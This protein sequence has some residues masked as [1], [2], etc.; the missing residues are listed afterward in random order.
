MYPN[1]L[2]ELLKLGYSEQDIEKICNGNILRVWSKVEQVAQ[3]MQS[4]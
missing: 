2:Y 3:D 1:I 4:K